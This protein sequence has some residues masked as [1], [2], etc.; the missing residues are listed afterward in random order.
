MT[1]SVGLDVG[2]T[3]VKALAVTPSGDIAA[4]GRARVSALDTAT[5]VVRAGSRRL[6]ACRRSSARGGLRRPRGRAGSGSPDRCTDSSRSTTPTGRCV[7]RSSGTTSERRGMR[8]DRGAGRPRTPDRAHGQPSAPRLHRPEGR[9]A[10]QPR[11]RHLRP[12][13]AHLPPQ[14]LR[15]PPAH[16]LVGDRRRRRFGHVALRRR[17]A[18]LEPGGRRRARDPR[19]VAPACPR[20]PG[21]LR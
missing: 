2:T 5:G 6:V 15:A 17:R 16:R 20:V 10:S 3:G 13:L 9:L 8:G 19:R 18:P 4:R 1:V 14:G 7:R 11:A 21:R 12:H